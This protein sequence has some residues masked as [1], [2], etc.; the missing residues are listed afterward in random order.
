MGGAAPVRQLAGCGLLTDL[1]IL[2]LL[3]GISPSLTRM[4]TAGG[5][6]RGTLG[7]RMTRLIADFLSDNRGGRRRR[8]IRYFE[9]YARAAWGLQVRFAMAVNVLSACPSSSKV[10]WSNSAKSLRPSCSAKLLAAP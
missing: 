7:P 6:A 1:L 4:V 8:R 3:F 5:G 10:C 2:D 9:R